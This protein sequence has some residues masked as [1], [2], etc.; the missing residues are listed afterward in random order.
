MEV[1][2][3]TNLISQGDELQ[4]ITQPDMNYLFKKKKKQTEK[5]LIP[6][7]ANFIQEQVQWIS[8][9]DQHFGSVSEL[10]GISARPRIAGWMLR[11]C[12]DTAPVSRSPMSLELP[13]TGLW[14]S[15]FQAEGGLLKYYRV[16]LNCGFAA[17]S[18]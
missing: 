5:R 14:L 18:D 7:H 8:A 4:K 16:E 3:I 1:L 17:E 11:A 9:A 6:K 13:Q 15:G 12:S 10:R 2:H